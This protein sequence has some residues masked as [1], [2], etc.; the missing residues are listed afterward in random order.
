MMP[1]PARLPAARYAAMP[2]WNR[3]TARRCGLDHGQLVQQVTLQV[4]QTALARHLLRLE[5]GNARPC[6]VTCAMW[7]DEGGQGTR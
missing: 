3:R 2:C 4:Q 5:Q 7:H 6:S 1:W